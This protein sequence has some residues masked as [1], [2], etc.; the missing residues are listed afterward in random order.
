MFDFSFENI[1]HSNLINFAVMITVIACVMAKLNLG[2]KIENLR[3]SIV[4]RVED[5]DTAKNDA[6]KFLTDTKK[7]VE[8]LGQE[9]AAIKD[10]AVKSADNM[11]NKII[12]D[13]KNQVDKF[14]QNAHK[15]IEN[16][17]AKVQSELKNEVSEL[18]IDLARNNIKEKLTQDNELH[19]KLINESIDKL[20]RVEF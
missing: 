10:N 4:K 15:N 14:E 18:S 20:D 6:D 5:S 13:A 2:E 9:L 11:A 7:S 3:N 17:F 1:L 8:N 16:E 19:K 12:E